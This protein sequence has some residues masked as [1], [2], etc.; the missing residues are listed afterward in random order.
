MTLTM[1]DK[2]SSLAQIK[3]Y[4]QV[5]AGIKF[6]AVSR[7]EKYKW[8]NNILT[9][10]RYV[11]LKS[12]KERGILK[13]Y[14]CRMT[15]MKPRQLK[16]LITKKIQNPTVPITLSSNWGK[17]NRFTTV[18]GPA[19]II[20]L[21]ETDNLHQR[22]NAY[23]TK[24]ILKAEYEYGD[25]RYKRLQ[26]ISVSHIYNLRRLRTYESHSTTFTSTNPVS[27]PIG[28]RRRPNNMGKPGYLRVDTVHQGDRRLVTGKYVKY[29][30]SYTLFPAIKSALIFVN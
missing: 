7:K 6:T 28:I 12:K 11:R 16:R 5:N 27:T 8:I 30:F 3:E 19:E 1:T 23:A 26:D 4:L 18:Y 24:Q 22:L 21:A 2:G 15:G 20:L 29:P 13:E 17:K 9:K 14:I 25:N 10:F